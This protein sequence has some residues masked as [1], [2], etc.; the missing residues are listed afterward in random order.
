MLVWQR[1][2]ELPVLAGA[3]RDLDEGRSALPDTGIPGEPRGTHAPQDNAEGRATGEPWPRRPHHAHERPGPDLAV[4]PLQRRDRPASG[5]G[6]RA[7][8][9][10]QIDTC[11]VATIPG[12][13][14][15]SNSSAGVASDSTPHPAG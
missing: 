7:P 6:P 5:I 4:E 14:T 13:A 11:G 10:R 15:T 1:A 8:G 3:G 9:D 12:Q 2:H